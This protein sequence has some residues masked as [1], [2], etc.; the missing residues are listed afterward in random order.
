M[1]DA[2][3]AGGYSF[4]KQVAA[5]L[6]G[7]MTHEILI[8]FDLIY[9]PRNPYRLPYNALKYDLCNGNDQKMPDDSGYAMGL[10]TRVMIF[11][12]N[13]TSDP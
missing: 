2:E 11:H 12:N 13:P 7:S 1:S 4:A 5:A 10:K 6:E 9:S 3:T 8:P